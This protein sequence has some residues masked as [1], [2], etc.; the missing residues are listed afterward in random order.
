MYLHHLQGS[1]QSI[2]KSEITNDLAPRLDRS[3]KPLIIGVEPKGQNAVARMR[4]GYAPKPL[5][6]EHEAMWSP[7]D[8]KGRDAYDHHENRLELPKTEQLYTN[9]A[10][11]DGTGKHMSKYPA[12]GGYHNTGSHPEVR[13]SHDKNTDMHAPVSGAVGHLRPGTASKVIMRED[14]TIMHNDV[15]VDIGER[16]MEE[17]A[18]EIAPQR[19]ERESVAPFPTP[20]TLGD[21]S[22]K[23]DSMFTLH[24]KDKTVHAHPKPPVKVGTP[25]GSAVQ[26]PQRVSQEVNHT[27]ALSGAKHGEQHLMGMEDRRQILSMD[28]QKLVQAALVKPRAVIGEYTLAQASEELDHMLAISAQSDHESR[29]AAVHGT[30]DSSHL[31]AGSANRTHATTKRNIPSVELSTD[32]AIQLPKQVHMQQGNVL[33]K[34]YTTLKDAALP[35][36]TPGGMQMTAKPQ[37]H[38]NNIQSRRR[39][40]PAVIKPFLNLFKRS[41][42]QQADVRSSKSSL[43]SA[44]PGHASGLHQATSRPGVSVRRTDHTSAVPTQNVVGRVKAMFQGGHVDLPRSSAVLDDPTSPPSIG[45]PVEALHRSTNKSTMALRTSNGSNA[46]LSP[47]MNSLQVAIQKDSSLMRPLGGGMPMHQPMM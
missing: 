33:M 18:A 30:D 36:R 22:S 12:S 41:T 35:T 24:R 16:K 11:P 7:D 14:M 29:I 8:T 26:L 10:R 17:R 32:K 1:K 47:P 38:V 43:Q 9:D 13:I 37:L 20:A 15:H 39:N 46:N 25:I 31:I 23:I 28:D 44:P 6:M 40:V 2:H 3:G 19:R 27:N 34:G 42:P 21:R 45:S 4:S 5:P